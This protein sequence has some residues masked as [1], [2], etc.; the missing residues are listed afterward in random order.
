[1]LEH[2]RVGVGKE[3]FRND[4]DQLSFYDSVFFP[5]YAPKP[6]KKKELESRSDHQMSTE[7]VALNTKDFEVVKLKV[8]AI[9]KDNKHRQRFFP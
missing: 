3:K 9:G 6:K 5:L 8:R 7:E 1:M 2:Y 4:N